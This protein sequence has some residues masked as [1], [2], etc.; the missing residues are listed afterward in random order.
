MVSD[1]SQLFNGLYVGRCKLQHRVVMSPLTR[2]RADDSS[3][4][5]PFVK[6]YY[7]QRASVPGTLLISEATA[8]SG[9][10]VGFSNVPGIWNT[11]QIQAW[12][13]I[14]NC[15]HSNGSFIF[16]QLW[17][18]GRSFQP[19]QALGESFDY[20]SSSPIPIEQEDPAPR[21]L[22]DEE[23]HLYIDKYATAARNAIIAGMDGVEIHG[24]N[25]YLI[26]Q[27]T[28][29]SCNQ[30]KDEWGGSLENRARLAL[31][32][33]KAVVDA[34]GSDRV[35]IKLTPWGKI[36]GMGTMLDL[37]PQFQYLI[38]K[39]REMG[40]AYLHLANSRWLDDM[41]EE[42]ERNDIFVRL[43]RNSSLVILE[44]GYDTKS[45]QEEVDV[46]LKDYNVAVAFGRFFIS[47]PDLP[48]RIKMGINLQDY[49]R[50]HFYS[51]LSKRGYIDYSFSNQFLESRRALST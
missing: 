40:L 31:E 30:R 33:T 45:A 35:G 13:E 23:I 11:E 21:E 15:V 48:F 18:T 36:Q 22:T 44:G 9:E 3:V 29:A 32:V 27:F 38:S 41:A 49:D 6:E 46:H 26:D 51:P 1:S 39:L 19:D 7:G 43:W 5:L 34:V 20:V 42:V 2:F 12:R 4:P 47:N 17:A 10:A 25:G 8:I 14:A 37:V 24:A 28:Q 16:L 50:E